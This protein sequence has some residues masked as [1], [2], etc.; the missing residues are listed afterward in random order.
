MGNC[1]LRKGVSVILYPGTDE[2][3]SGKPLLV[4]H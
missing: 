3:M 4:Y 2:R 1:M